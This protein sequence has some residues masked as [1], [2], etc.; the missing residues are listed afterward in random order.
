MTALG[1]RLPENRLTK[2][3][4]FRILN[5]DGVRIGNLFQFGKSPVVQTP[6]FSFIRGFMRAGNVIFQ[7]KKAR[8][9]IGNGALKDSGK[10][11]LDIENRN[12]TLKARGGT[13]R[14]SRR[15][16]RWLTIRACCVEKQ[17]ITKTF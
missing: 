9:E 8:F 2:S 16:K 14:S 7:P 17:G 11:V 6:D 15:T 10:A 5:I 13:L 4:R 12:Q 1:K 3:D